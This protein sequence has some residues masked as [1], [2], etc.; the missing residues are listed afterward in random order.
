MAKEETKAGGS[1]VWHKKQPRLV[2][3][4]GLG[5]FQFGFEVFSIWRW[6]GL[7]G[8]RNRVLWLWFCSQSAL[9]AQ[10]EQAEL[11]GFGIYQPP[12]AYG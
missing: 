12:M 4:R 9:L 2:K 10:N 3:G 1:R 6:G 11:G 8:R 5:R 7:K